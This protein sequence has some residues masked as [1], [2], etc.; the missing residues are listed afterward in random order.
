MNKFLLIIVSSLFCAQVFGNFN[1]LKENKSKAKPTASLEELKKILN[2]KFYELENF[3]REIDVAGKKFLVEYTL[4]AIITNKI[5]DLLKNSKND[6][7]AA[8]VVNNNNGDVLSI[9][10]YDKSKNIFGREIALNATSPAASLFKV[11]TAAELLENSD[12]TKN[13]LFTYN[14]KSST[15]YRSQLKDTPSK[16]WSRTI[17]FENAFAKS[18]NVIFAKAAIKESKPSSLFSMATKFGFNKPV[19]DIIDTL[20]S[21]TFFPENDYGFAELASG[22]NTET[23]ISPLHA[24]ML[25]SVVASDGVFINP[26]IVKKIIDK[27]S[28]EVIYKAPEDSRKVLT[29]EASKELQEMMKDTVKY[30]TARRAFSK[31]TK[32]I[33]NLDIGGKTGSITGGIPFGKRDWFVSYAMPTNGENDKGISVAIMVVNVKKW[34]VKSTD[35]AKNII[36]YYFNE[37]KNLNKVNL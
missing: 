37:Y 6:Y 29:K 7:V 20:P 8:V 14:G 28:G 11:I 16:R 34:H 24:T 31:R 23:L 26:K 19:L 35:L 22:F 18:N 2:K 36:E 1:F 5:K 30:G 10:D 9:V 33:Q 25:T 3:D 17:T 32:K 12:V 15:L 13:T 4:D 21:K 27:D